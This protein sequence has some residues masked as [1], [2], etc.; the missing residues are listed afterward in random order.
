MERN[1]MWNEKN[2]VEWND[3]ELLW[4]ENGIRIFKILDH[5]TKALPYKVKKN[6]SILLFSI[7]MLITLFQAKVYL[8]FSIYKLVS[9]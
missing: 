3:R 4:N 9:F 8:Y 6:Q 5:Y 1:G 2:L 7:L